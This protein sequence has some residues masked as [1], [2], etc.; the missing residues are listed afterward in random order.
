MRG[1][2]Q[3]QMGN[4]EYLLRKFLS[5]FVI[6]SSNNLLGW[7]KVEHSLY[8]QANIFALKSSKSMW[9]IGVQICDYYEKEG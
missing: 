4:G 6:P 3:E 2:I 5:V 9:G 1:N 8:F 7:R